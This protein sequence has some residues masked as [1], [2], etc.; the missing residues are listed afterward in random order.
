MRLKAI[1]RSEEECTRERSS[2]LA[3]VH[4]N[5]DPALHPLQRATEVTRAL[6]AAKLARLFAK[7][8]VA[9]LDG[10]G[11]GLTCLARNP[12]A[13]ACLLS[14]A[15]NGE[16]MLWDLASR[17][18]TASLRAHGRAVRGCAVAGDGRHAVSV[19][20]DSKLCLW[21]L[22]APR[23]HAA[24]EA[25]GGERPD[26]LQP[27]ATCFG[28]HAFRDVD[29]H[30]RRAVCATAGATVQL[31][32]HARSQ[33][34]AEFSWGADTV[35][36]VRFNPSEPDL[37]ASCGS[38]RSIALYDVRAATPL[39]KLV[40]LK[41]CNR[42]AWNPREAF[43]FTAASEDNNLYSFD[44]RRLDAATC[45]HKDF[46]SA[47][48]DVDYSPTGR[49]FVAGSYDRSVRIFGVGAG[50][51]REVYHTR[52]MQRVL[53]VRF[54]A[55]GGYVLSGSEDMNV[56]VWKA[57]AS[58]ALG[59]RLPRER[60]KAAYDAA[61]VARY[62][63]VPEVGRLVRQRHVPKA[64][65]KAASLRRTMEDSQ[66]RKKENVRKHSAEGTVETKP[67]RKERLVAELH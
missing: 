40:M 50:H 46:V 53:A 57:E 28:A 14:G 52:R 7:P 31:W 63:H 26:E 12:R 19:G 42:L 59:T 61:L 35:A 58:A 1:S 20:D 23:A 32:D 25:A 54:S 22:P 6:A 16:L 37:F 13:A 67:A 43:N 55:D 3:K 29:H 24:A 45:V 34:T 30:W 64:V 41:R 66:R 39:R 4:R 15:A 60:K 18:C 17:R 65:R 47:V 33:H 9:A 11:D 48:M 2:D 21:Q 8:F 51:S 56:R 5:L 38:D 36:S 10:H 27:V 62:A 44:M 49:E